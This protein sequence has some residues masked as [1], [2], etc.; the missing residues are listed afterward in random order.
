MVNFSPTNNWPNPL[1]EVALA[2]LYQDERYLLQL[3]DNIPTILY[4]GYWSLFGGHLEAGE[5]PLM[6]VE[7]E[8]WEEITL[9]MTNPSFFGCYPDTTAIRHVFF[10]PLTVSLDQLQLQEG[11][12]WG[13]VSPKAIAEG[14]IYSTKAG[15]KRPL[16]QIHQKILLDF[17]KAALK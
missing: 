15:G 7:R 10:A 6:A 17:I 11:W 4:P 13:L 12:D 14:Y 9:K 3:R 1:P 16:G 2:I 8:I 5:T